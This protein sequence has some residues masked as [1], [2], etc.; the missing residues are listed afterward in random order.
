MTVTF[1]LTEYI[2]ASPDECYRAVSRF[3]IEIGTP[4]VDDPKDFVEGCIKPA[5]GQRSAQKVWDLVLLVAATARGLEA[6]SFHQQGQCEDAAATSRWDSKLKVRVR[7]QFIQLH[8]P[9]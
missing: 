6:V 9:A 4:A 1:N 3:A 2:Q 8:S 5:I 7:A